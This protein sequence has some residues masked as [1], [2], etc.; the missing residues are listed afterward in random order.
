MNEFKE[1]QKHFLKYQKLFGLTGYKIYFKHELLNA[2]YANIT[3]NQGDMVATISLDNNISKED[4]KLRSVKE[5]AKHEAIHLLLMKLENRAMD[6]YV[7]P[8]EID[9]AVEELVFKLEDLINV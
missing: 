2:G 1:F 6:R 4:R 3:V 9:E 8:E 7:R 5:N